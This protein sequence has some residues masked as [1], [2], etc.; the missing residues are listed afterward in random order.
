MPTIVTS[1]ALYAGLPLVTMVGKVFQSRV[2]ASL[3]NALDMTE[4]V[5]TSAG[6]Y[7]ARALELASNPALLKA[8]REKLARNVKSAPLYDSARFVKGVEATYEAMLA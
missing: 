6:D 4:L 8:T 2:A 3:L 1:D 7:E 5:T